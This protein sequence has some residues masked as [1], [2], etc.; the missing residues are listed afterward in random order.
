MALADYLSEKNILLD[1]M[2]KDK[3][4]ALETLCAEASHLSAW[5]YSEIL[6]VVLER[7]ARSST[8]LANGVALPHGKSPL[9]VHPFLLLARS[10]AGVDFESLDGEPAKIFVLLLTPSDKEGREHLSLLAKLGAILKSEATVGEILRAKTQGEIFQI[11]LRR[12]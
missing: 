6:K 3:R 10:T 11:M 9:F 2:P 1:F 5:S 7:E 8:G 4:E 12:G